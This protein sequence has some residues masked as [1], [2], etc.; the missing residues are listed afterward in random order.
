RATAD[1]ADV[2]CCATLIIVEFVQAQRLVRQFDDGVDAFARVK[3]GVRGATD[4]ANREAADPLA[5]G[6]DDA[7]SDRGFEYERGDGASGFL[8]DQIARSSAADLFVA[9]QQQRHRV[10]GREFLFSNRAQ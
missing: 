1:D 3:S 2:D 6:L 9:G 8:L 4:G 10:R 7:A 5:R